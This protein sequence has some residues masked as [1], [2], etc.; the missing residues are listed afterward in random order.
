MLVWLIAVLA[1]LSRRCLLQPP[2]SSDSAWTMASLV[3]SGNK[4][5]LAMTT[6]KKRSILVAILPKITARWR[7]EFKNHKNHK[8][9]EIHKNTKNHKIHKNHEIKKKLRNS[10][11]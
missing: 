2:K 7:I 10:Q 9:H 5:C 8:I 11:N 4:G 6:C 3:E 1:K